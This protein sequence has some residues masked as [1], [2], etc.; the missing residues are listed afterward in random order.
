MPLA[1]SN[2][3]IIKSV[4]NYFIGGNDAKNIITV[5][6]NGNSLYNTAFVYN[7]QTG[8]TPIPTKIIIDSMPNT[9]GITPFMTA[10]VSP[11]TFSLVYLAVTPEN[12]ILTNFITPTV[13][14]TV[15]PNC[16]ISI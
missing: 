9:G 6:S 5:S 8:A 15:F 13:S 14:T 3:A 10:I 16:V 4:P 1:L 2:G 7:F 11:Y 12:P